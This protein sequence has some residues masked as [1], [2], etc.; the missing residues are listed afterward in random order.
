MRITAIRTSYC[1]LWSWCCFGE[2]AFSSKEKP[3]HLPPKLGGGPSWLHVAKNQG[4]GHSLSAFCFPVARCIFVCASLS[5]CTKGDF[6]ALQVVGV[7]GKVAVGTLL[8]LTYENAK[9]R[10]FKMSSKEKNLGENQTVGHKY[11]WPRFSWC[12]SLLLPPQRWL[13][14]TPAPLLSFALSS[15][16][17]R[18]SMG[19][20]KT[21][22]SKGCQNQWKCF[23]HSLKT[24][25]SL[26]SFLCFSTKVQP[27]PQQEEMFSVH[28][29]NSCYTLM[30]S[31]PLNPLLILSLEIF[32]LMFS[33]GSVAYPICLVHFLVFFCLI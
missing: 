5:C 7:A 24:K 25:G 31:F 21:F 33:L 2:G 22:S 23:W 15:L 4:L 14:W 6:F 27:F 13:C 11:H 12:V 19:F 26:F 10:G 28:F 32:L 30:F 17:I 9:K 20:V 8:P 3:G 18:L 16:F 29:T 1:L